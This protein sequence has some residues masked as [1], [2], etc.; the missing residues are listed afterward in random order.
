MRKFKKVL[1]KIF[2]KK[3]FSE[4]VSA[5]GITSRLIGEEEIWKNK[6]P[7]DERCSIKKIK[8]DLKNKKQDPEELCI[9]VY[10]RKKLPIE[11]K[12]PTKYKGM[13]VYNMG[14]F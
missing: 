3:P 13:K 14:C 11:L 6:V 7:E 12:L 4:Y 1:K 2:E 8:K 10:V 5:V 9:A